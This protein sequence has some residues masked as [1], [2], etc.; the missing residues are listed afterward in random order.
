MSVKKNHK[1]VVIG[2]GPGGYSAAL[3]GAL[4]GADVVL[5][6]NQA[7][8]GSATLTDVVP[9]KT[10]IASAERA[11]FVAQGADFGIRFQ[12]CVS[13]D[14]GHINRRIMDLTRAQS[15]DMFS[16][17]TGAGVRVVYGHAA[18]DGP[19]R[20]LVSVS[21]QEKYEFFANTVVV[22]TGSS[23]RV[24][25]NAI[26]D[27]KRILT[28][29]QLYTLEQVPEHI[30]VV[31]SGVTGAEFASA[32]RN[33][34]SE[35]TLV[36]SRDRVLPGGD[37][38]AADLI[39]EVFINSGMK[40]LNRARAQAAAACNGG[41]VVTLTDG[42]EVRGTH[43]LMAVG[44]VPNTSGIGLETANIAL[45]PAGRITVNRVACSSVPG[46]YAAGD[47]SDFLPL[48]SVAEM[49][50]QVAVYHAMGENANP[51]EL[52][53]LASTVFTTPEIATVGRSE[54]AIDKARATALKVDLAT[55]SRAKILGI[56][57]G[58]VKMIVS[59]ETGT[60]LGGVV[61]APNASDL[62]FPISVAV[63]NRLSADQ[64]S[65][66]FAVYP[67]L[68]ISLWHAAR[69]SHVRTDSASP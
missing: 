34:G 47:C 52:K 42:T 54:K 26:P 43:C 27:G 2:G 46:V 5:I 18:L 3:S 51:I 25:P 58:F 10:L 28:W 69:A 19:N 39:Q 59:R 38:D 57:T 61:V 24:L 12:N 15:A 44:S 13:A 36:S 21:G 23:P 67:S 32:F 40:L 41:V 66:S 14:I 65:Q 55:N 20:V 50:G 62:I 1:I 53:N 63:Q 56:K 7:V 16:T 31:G 49:Q 45:N 8:G 29:K 4:L 6:E 22:A 9:S 64:L 30:I 33:L 68:T 11:V 17:L 60:V 48:A 35:V 37:E